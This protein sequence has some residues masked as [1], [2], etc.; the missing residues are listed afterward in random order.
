MVYQLESDVSLLA[1]NVKLMRIKTG[2]DRKRLQMDLDKL[3]DCLDK[4]LL[5]F[6]PSKC[7]VMK[8]GKCYED[9]TRNMDRS[10]RLGSKRKT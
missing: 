3:Q 2:K 9:W 8:I 6:K 5:E 1:D 7:K 10:Y 4:R